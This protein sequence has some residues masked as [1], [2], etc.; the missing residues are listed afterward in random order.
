MLSKK[1]KIFFFVYICLITLALITSN[2]IMPFVEPNIIP[3]IEGFIDKRFHKDVIVVLSVSMTMPI[4]FF[5]IIPNI[6]HL[7]G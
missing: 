2:F 1:L 5:I 4:M 6:K 7:V 3:F